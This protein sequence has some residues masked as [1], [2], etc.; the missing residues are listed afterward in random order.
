MIFHKMHVVEIMVLTSSTGLLM[1]LRL[2]EESD[3]GIDKRGLS[4]SSIT[5]VSTGKSL[6]DRRNKCDSQFIKR[7]KMPFSERIVPHQSIHSWSNK[8]WFGIV[9]SSYN[10]SQKIITKPTSNLQR[11]FVDLLNYLA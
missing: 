7:Q 9:P 6:L 4:H 2:P 11:V 3:S 1:S 8:Q 10:A 5:V